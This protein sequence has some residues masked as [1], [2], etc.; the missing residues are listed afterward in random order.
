M[1][2]KDSIKTIN[3][4]IP[5]GGDW[6]T[7]KILRCLNRGPVKAHILSQS[8]AAFARF[9][10]LCISCHC[11]KSDDEN[12]RLQTLIKIVR[13]LAIDVVLPVTEKGTEFVVRNHSAVSEV[14]NLPLLPRYDKLNLAGEKWEF[15]CYIKKLDLPVASTVLISK[16]GKSSELDILKY[17]ALLK[18]TK[19]SGGHGI[20]KM[21]SCADIDKWF[22]RWT[23]S[24]NSKKYI[25]QDYIPGIDYCLSVICKKG[26]IL[27]YTLQ[28][29]LE[30]VSGYFGPQ[31]VMEFVQDEKILALGG[32]LMSAME[33]EGIACID[34]R[35]DERDN[36]PKLIEVNPRFGQAVLGSLLAGVNFPLIACLDAVGESCPTTEYRNIKYA[37]PQAYMKTLIRR[38]CGRNPCVPVH[39][40]QSGLYF[41]LG[42]PLPEMVDIFRKFKSRFGGKNAKT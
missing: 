34:F 9:S 28:K 25:L 6:E 2:R 42:D 15:Y 39:Y 8:R 37:H 20:I 32:R 41:A 14:T 17:P 33:W 24:T 5:D 23:A 11:Y 1:L 10:R 31:R 4:L 7:V 3:V 30:S 21:N 35:I 16:L 13:D 38:V 40:K 36:E 29:D 19:S 22:D 26:E 12:Q 18:P 27:A